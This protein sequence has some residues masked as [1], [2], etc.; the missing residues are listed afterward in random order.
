MHQIHI[1]PPFRG[2]CLRFLAGS[3]AATPRRGKKSGEGDNGAASLW[4]EVSPVL[5]VKMIRLFNSGDVTAQ[6]P[7]CAD[8]VGVFSGGAQTRRSTLTRNTR[9]PSRAR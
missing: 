6:L 5:R 9:G 7:V 1:Q 3:K 4:P 2:H 8:A